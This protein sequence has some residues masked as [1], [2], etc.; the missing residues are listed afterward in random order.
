M[1]RHQRKRQRLLPEN[2]ADRIDPLRS[3]LSEGPF[4]SPP[5]R[6]HSPPSSCP[7]GRRTRRTRPFAVTSPKTTVTARGDRGR[8]E[9]G[10]SRSSPAARAKHN[11]STGQLTHAGASGVQTVAP[12]SINAWVK[13]PG[14]SGETSGAAIA[15]TRLRT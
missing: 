8:E 1:E 12:R 14:R 3:V 13:A 5:G 4:L 7:F 15:G 11:R 6:A 2:P 9:I 10:S